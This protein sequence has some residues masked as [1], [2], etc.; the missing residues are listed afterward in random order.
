MIKFNGRSR[1][2]VYMPSKPIRFGFKVYLMTDAQNSY[3]LNWIIH[4]RS[5]ESLVSLLQKVT[6]NFENR[7]F[8]ISMDRYYSTLDVI[9]DLTRR[10]FGVYATIKGN[11]IKANSNMKKELKNIKQGESRFYIF[12]DEKMLLTCWKDSKLVVLIS[13]TGDDN[14]VT[15]TRNKNIKQN[16][17]ICYKRLEVECPENITTYSKNA[18]GI[19]KFDQ[20]ISYYTVDHKSVKWYLR[21]ILHLLS[22]AIHNSFILYSNAKGKKS[23]FTNY[24]DFEKSIINSLLEGMRQRKNAS[25]S[26]S[27]TSTSTKIISSNIF[28]TPNRLIRSRSSTSQSFS[29]NSTKDDCR[30]G[31]NSKSNCSLCETKNKKKRTN[32]WCITHEIPVCVLNCYDD[33][34]K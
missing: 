2:K 19:D 30:I 29:G 25:K 21:I 3:V 4:E 17:D 22:V 32:F 26:N 34:R 8:I 18:R 33:H 24:L 31:Y 5:K 12:E 13:N 1:M 7:G 27:T 9:K 10:G 28:Q 11:R 6:E 14:I 20:I 15:I 16:G 23:R